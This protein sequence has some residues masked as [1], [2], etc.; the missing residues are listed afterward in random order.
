MSERLTAGDVMDAGQVAQ[1]LHLPRSTV[2]DL[3]RRGELPSVK[4][5]R[6]RIFLRP[7]LEDLL[8]GR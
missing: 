8:L 7:H 1:L 5:G 2:Y 3:A 4:L 6:R